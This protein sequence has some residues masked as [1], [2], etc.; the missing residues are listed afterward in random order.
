MCVSVI[1]LLYPCPFD[2]E[3]CTL[4]DSPPTRREYLVTSPPEFC[5][6]PKVDKL[7]G[8]PMPLKPSQGLFRLGAQIEKGGRGWIPLV[9]LF[10]W[11]KSGAQPGKRFCRT[12]PE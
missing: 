3:S 5:A 1:L 11:I 9:F 7:A 2:D 8:V 12:R 10:A 6:D 4:S